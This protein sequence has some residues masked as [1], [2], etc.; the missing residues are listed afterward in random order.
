MDDNDLEPSGSGP[1]LIGTLVVVG[2]VVAE[3][4]WAGGA[5]DVDPFSKILVL[6]ATAISVGS[7]VTIQLRMD[8]LKGDPAALRALRIGRILAASALALLAGTVLGFF[9]G[10]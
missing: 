9:V 3:L 4:A 7:L 6:V 2:L 1:R 5:E 8:S 10:H